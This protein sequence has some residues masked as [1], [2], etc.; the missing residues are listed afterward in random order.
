MGEGLRTKVDRGI[1]V[2]AQSIPEIEVTLHN[3][4]WVV[5]NFS[6]AE[7][8]Y[9]R[10]VSA[11]PSASFAGRFAA[12]EAVIKAISNSDM[13]PHTRNLWKGSAAPLVDI[14]ILP[15]SSGAPSAVLAGHAKEVADLLGITVI[16][17]AISHSGEYAVAQAHVQ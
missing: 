7:I 12:K 9:C 15:S 11:D 14:E 6:P 8:N 5:R 3:S 1:G 10:Y 16:R 2:D 17:V 13:D 4:E